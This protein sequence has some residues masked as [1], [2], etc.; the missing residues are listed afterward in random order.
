MNTSLLQSTD[1]VHETQISTADSQEAM[2]GKCNKKMFMDDKHVQ[3][4]NLSGIF[5]QKNT[6]KGNLK[7]KARKQA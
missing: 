2:V 7:S 3:N 5:P 4:Q 1:D 6:S